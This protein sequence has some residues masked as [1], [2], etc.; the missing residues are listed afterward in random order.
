MKYSI[1]LNKLAKLEKIIAKYQ[2]K[3]AN[4]T[5]EVGDEVIEDGTL[6]IDDPMN[7]TSHTTTIKVTCR[8]VDVEDE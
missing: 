3:G 6:Y 1:P 2:K 8:E 7:H 5:F 4:I